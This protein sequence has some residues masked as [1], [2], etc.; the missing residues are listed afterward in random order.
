MALR[1]ILALSLKHMGQAPVGDQTVIHTDEKISISMCHFLQRCKS[2]AELG[3]VYGNQ[4]HLQEPMPP[5]PEPRCG[6]AIF[7]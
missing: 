1:M 4:A 3:E 2:V 5:L 7:I 6:S